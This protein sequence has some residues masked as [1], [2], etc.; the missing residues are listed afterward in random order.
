MTKKQ[1]DRPPS[2]TLRRRRPDKLLDLLLTRLQRRMDLHLPC[3]RDRDQL[4]W[5]EGVWRVR[6]LVR[7]YQGHHYYGAYREFSSDFLV[8][9]VGE[10][11]RWGLTT[12]NDC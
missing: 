11:W 8:E 7:E 5:R 2:R 12:R 3:R 10:E 9:G 6:V 4:V 1:G